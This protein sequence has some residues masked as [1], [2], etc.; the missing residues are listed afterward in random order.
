MPTNN[1]W[2]DTAVGDIFN[3]PRTLWLI[4]CSEPYSVSTVT[5][6]LHLQLFFSSQFGLLSSVYGWNL[7]NLRPGYIECH[8]IFDTSTF[9]RVSFIATRSASLTDRHPRLNKN[10]GVHSLILQMVSAFC[11]DAFNEPTKGSSDSAPRTDRHPAC[12]WESPAPVKIG[13]SSRILSIIPAPVKDNAYCANLLCYS[14]IPNL[15][16]TNWKSRPF[17]GTATTYIFLF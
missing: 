4:I 12:L 9:S 5:R 10:W 8:D 16:L 2:G 13:P 7:L 11:G 14:R 17:H 6:L 1:C 15:A 3:W